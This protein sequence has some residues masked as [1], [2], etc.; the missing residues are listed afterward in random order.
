MRNHTIEEAGHLEGYVEGYLVIKFFHALL[1]TPQI[2][3]R[4]VAKVLNWPQP[5]LSAFLADDSETVRTVSFDD[6]TVTIT[7]NRQRYI[8]VF[9]DKCRRY[10]LYPK[11]ESKLEL[12]F[13]DALTWC[14]LYDMEETDFSIC[15]TADEQYACGDDAIWSALRNEMYEKYNIDP[16]NCSSLEHDFVQAAT[17]EKA[18]KTTFRIKYCDPEKGE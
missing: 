4:L 6:K 1:L 17:I 11:P 12:S 8:D 7:R 2:P 5:V 16:M 3:E 14:T 18:Q 10:G 15:N 13:I 9:H